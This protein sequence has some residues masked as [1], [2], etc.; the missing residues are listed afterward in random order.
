MENKLIVIEKSDTSTS[1]VQEKKHSE[2]LTKVNDYVSKDEFNFIVTE[3]NIAV[4]KNGN[5]ELNKTIA[6]LKE[7]TKNI[8][9]SE[10]I[11][12]D[13]LKKNSK[14]YQE[15]IEEK[16]KENLKKIAVFEDVKKAKAIELSKVY[17][18][19]KIAE[20][21]LREEFNKI[22]TS[23]M[24]NIGNIT[25]SGALTG[26]AKGAKTILDSKIQVCLNAQNRY[27]L[28][29][30]NLK[31][32]CY[33]KGLKAPLTENYVQGIIF[34]TNDSEYESKL[35][36]MIADEI[37]RLNEIEN[38]I[39]KEAEK[40]AEAEAKEKLVENINKLNDSFFP[41]I[42]KE[43]NLAELNLIK[44]QIEKYDS[45]INFQALDRVDK[46]IDKM[47]VFLS[48]GTTKQEEKEPVTIKDTI[49]REIEIQCKLIEDAISNDNNI[50][51]ALVSD[52]KLEEIKNKGVGHYTI[53]EI[54]PESTEVLTYIPPHEAKKIVLKDEE[55]IKLAEKIEQDTRIVTIVATFEV[56]V[57]SSIKDE[58]VVNK[59]RER[60]YECDI[61]EDTLKKLEV[62]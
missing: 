43:T 17:V 5:A 26:G 23:D 16:R 38:E 32:V 59:V 40:K 19:D 45:T 24:G 35:N 50:P 12:I 61:K 29:V 36:N 51:T 60:L 22:D 55:C 37:K 52:D 15:I 18:A 30:S 25:K 1:L 9:N 44:I 4:V 39:I 48:S 11:N 42:E 28:R 41:L 58:P 57:P 7:V 3:E 53:N 14:T 21:G 47:I 49:P 20:L 6:L 8:V 46:K 34:I 54:T 31:V 56:K 10:S 27:D 2:I 62:I 33:E 13:K